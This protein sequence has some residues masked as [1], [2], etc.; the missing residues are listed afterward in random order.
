MIDDEED[1]FEPLHGLF[2]TLWT[3]RSESSRDREPS[4]VYYTQHKITETGQLSENILT[5]GDLFWLSVG[6]LPG[7]NG[8]I[9]CLENVEE[10]D[11]D[12]Q[13]RQTTRDPS[14]VMEE[15]EEP[16]SVCLLIMHR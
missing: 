14:Y 13:K 5:I 9:Y 16:W 2:G 7:A 15:R 10:V 4:K 3:R 1:H 12:E 8:N 6:S 11:V